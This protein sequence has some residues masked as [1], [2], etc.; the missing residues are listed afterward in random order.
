MAEAHI[1]LLNIQLLTAVGLRNEFMQLPV[2]SKVGILGRRMGKREAEV[3][4]GE[5]NYPGGHGLEGAEA[6]LHSRLFG[7]KA[8]HPPWLP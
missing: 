6:R 3:Q 7:S 4:R 1:P 5:A 8:Q 2:C